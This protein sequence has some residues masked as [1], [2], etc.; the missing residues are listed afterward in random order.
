MYLSD[1]A[2]ARKAILGTE[3]EFKITDNKA[4]LNPYYLEGGDITFDAFS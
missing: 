1:H 3:S 2:K 4:T